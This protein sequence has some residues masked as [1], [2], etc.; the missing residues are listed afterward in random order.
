MSNP[1]IRVANGATGGT[2]IGGTALTSGTFSAIQVIAD[3][4]LHTL[5]GNIGGGIENTTEGSAATL[6]A[7]TIIY[8]QFSAI[9]LHSGSVVAYKA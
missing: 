8:G 1:N 5:T 9:K 2:F 3:A 4:K 7:G 6:L